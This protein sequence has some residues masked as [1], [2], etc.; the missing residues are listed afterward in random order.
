LIPA[1]FE[2]WRR[3]T[4]LAERVIQSLHKILMLDAQLAMESYI[5]R[6]EAKLSFMNRELAETSRGLER[7]VELEQGR[8]RAASE[9]A[10]ASEELASIATIV[11][12]LAHEIGTPMGVIQG[13]AELLEKSVGDERGRARL[14]TIREQIDR[15]SHIIQTLLNMA[16][17]SAR[18]LG[19]VDLAALLRETLAFLSEKL[20]VHGIEVSF[21][22]VA[23]GALVHGD[24]DKLQQLLINLMLNA[25][26]AMP[27]GGKLDVSLQVRA[28]G[29]EIQVA[30]NGV[31]MTPD[32][33]SR[34]FDPFF[35]TKEAGQGNGLGLV[36]ARGIVSDHGGEIHVASTPGS[37][38]TFVLT[39]PLHAGAQSEAAS[40]SGA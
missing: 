4:G 1:I 33:V 34:I 23:A 29:A 13:H 16:R 18:Q 40:K 21:A 17:P 19:P 6:R 10:R 36:V 22:Q 25:V 35:T 12:G 7:Q 28:D 27:R 32:V 39:F 9:R 5:E 24:H 8:V 20:R 26:D 11:A 30:D 31:G 3:D 14:A 15:I 38:T 2:H 37:G